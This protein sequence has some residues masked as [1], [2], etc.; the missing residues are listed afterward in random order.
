MP[1]I[2][3]KKSFFS[4]LLISLRKPNTSPNVE[5]EKAVLFLLFLSMYAELGVQNYF[6]PFS[7][8]IL[9]LNTILDLLH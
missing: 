7:F 9:F 6:F 1:T 8:I 4:L 5:L 2:Y 3:N